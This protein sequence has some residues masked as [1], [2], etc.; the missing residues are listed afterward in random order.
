LAELEVSSAEERRRVRVVV[1][2]IESVLRLLDHLGVF[3][4]CEEGVGA[5]DV[6]L[7]S[8]AARTRHDTCNTA[9]EGG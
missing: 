7:R 1:L 4:L 8:L 2:C 9:N 3:L 5:S 6:C